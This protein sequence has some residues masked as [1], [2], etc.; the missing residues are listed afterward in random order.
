MQK[1]KAKDEKRDVESK[2][3]TVYNEVQ[4]MLNFST[5]Y[6]N[7]TKPQGEMLPN[8]YNMYVVGLDLNAT[9]SWDKVELMEE[10]Q[11]MVKTNFLMSGCQLKK[12]EEQLKLVK[13]R[14]NFLEKKE[15]SLEAE[16]ARLSEKMWV[17][18]LEQRKL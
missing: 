5:M 18:E 16:V 12:K 9:W 14:V 2:V 8:D 11:W 10:T 15:K 7:T 3:Y 13:E 17:E 6:W 4:G 1:K